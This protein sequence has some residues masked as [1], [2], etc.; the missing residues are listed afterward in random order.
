MN[1]KK[2]KRAITLAGRGPAAGLHIGVLRYFKS[3]GIEFDVWAV[4]NIGAW[5]A[6]VYNQADEGR[7]VEQTYEFFR[8]DVFRSDESYQ[9]FP[10]NTVS[11][12]DWRGNA[13]AIAR[14]LLEPKNYQDLLLPDEIMQSFRRSMWLLS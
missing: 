10:T 4:A 8:D 3:A 2:P 12:P 14:F 6:V 13:N 11:A 9:G 1:E 7:E 5:F